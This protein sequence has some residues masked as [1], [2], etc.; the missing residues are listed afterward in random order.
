MLLPAVRLAYI[1]SFE[2]Y[3]LRLTLMPYT[4]SKQSSTSCG[5]YSVQTNRLISFEV[6]SSFGCGSGHWKPVDVV[7]SL[8]LETNAGAGR[9]VGVTG[10]VSVT[11]SVG[12]SV[13][14]GEGATVDSSVGACVG[15]A[16]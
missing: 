12:I 7:L 14:M 11:T 15:C 6:T 16:G 9:A 5:I 10:I 1:S 3:S 2:E 4:C 8:S 13:A